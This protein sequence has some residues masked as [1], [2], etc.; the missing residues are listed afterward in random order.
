MLVVAQRYFLTLGNYARIDDRQQASQPNNST[1]SKSTSISAPNSATIPNFSITSTTKFSLNNN[2]YENATFRLAQVGSRAALKFAFAHLRRAW[3]SGEDAD[4]CSELLQES[5]EALQSLPEATLFGNVSISPVWLE[6]M[7]R[8]S[9]FLRQVVLG[10]DEKGVT[11]VQVPLTDKHTA[12]GL[13]LELATQRG[14][15]GHILDSVL[16]LLNLWEKGRYPT[17]NRAKSSDTSAPLVPILKRYERLAA[18]KTPIISFSYEEQISPTKCLLKF[19]QIPDLDDTPIDL[20]QA[21]VI[22]LSALDCMAR[23]YLE[24]RDRRQEVFSWNNGTLINNN[25][26]NIQT[27]SA[28][29]GLDIQQI[30]CSER[31]FLVLTHSGQVYSLNYQ[32]ENQVGFIK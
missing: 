29:S 9:K 22:I 23:N 1:F 20:R 12:L 26:N 14:S 8:S 5:L 19:V 18:V 30:V 6:I 32:N 13:L 27:C 7:D 2:N 24:K 3:R 21:A 15:L 10:D 17:D 16:L 4:L 25:C 11:G 31:Y 28:L